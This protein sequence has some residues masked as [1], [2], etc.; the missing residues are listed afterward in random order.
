[1][2]SRA[3][4]DCNSLRC[5]H[6]ECDFFNLR[7]EEYVLVEVRFPFVLYI[8]TFHHALTLLQGIEHSLLLTHSLVFDKEDDL[9]QTGE[10]TDFG[11]MSNMKKCPDVYQINYEVPCLCSRFI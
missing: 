6:I 1:M 3:S 2:L 11:D 10:G 8:G 5:T 4:V 9:Q 7:E